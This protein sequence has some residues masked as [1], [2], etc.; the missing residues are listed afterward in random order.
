M[1]RRHGDMGPGGLA[2]TRRQGDAAS[3]R[4]GDKGPRGSGCREVPRCRLYLRGGGW[5][6]SPGAG[7]ERRR[8]G[9]AAGRGRGATPASPRTPGWGGR[10][11][12]AVSA[13]HARHPPLARSSPAVVRRAAGNGL[14]SSLT[15]VSCPRAGNGC[16]GHQRTTYRRATGTVHGC[17][18][19]VGV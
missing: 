11:R 4:H 18:A 3:G 6:H 13:S 14:R 2:V 5:R 15:A 19:P 17:E 8:A 12:R 10:E 9:G 1:S 16:D 7:G